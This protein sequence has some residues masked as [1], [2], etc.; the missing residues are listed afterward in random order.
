MRRAIADH[1]IDECA[2]F[3]ERVEYPFVTDPKHPK[4]YCVVKRAGTG[5]FM[6]SKGYLDGYQVWIYT[7]PGDLEGL[8]ALAEEVKSALDGAILENTDS[9]P[10][11]RR[12]QWAGTMQDFPDEKLDAVCTRVDFACFRT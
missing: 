4:P 9:P 2:S 1:L 8:D 10:K 5:S 6:G 7:T 11:S 12:L 3:E